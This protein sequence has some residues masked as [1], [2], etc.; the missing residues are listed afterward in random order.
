MRNE[1]RLPLVAV[2]TTYS[3]QNCGSLHLVKAVASKVRAQ[4]Q[5]VDLSTA[6]C[7]HGCWSFK[8][9]LCPVQKIKTKFWCVPILV[10]EV[11]VS[12]D[13][14]SLFTFRVTH[15]VWNAIHPDKAVFPLQ[16]ECCFTYRLLILRSYQWRTGC[17]T[18]LYWP[19]TQMADSNG[20]S[21]RKKYAL[22]V[23]QN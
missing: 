13:L 9:N 14:H 18:V 12:Y 23:L 20:Y 21:E 11:P 8:P 6:F 3:F 5:T 16:V 2:F 4:I 17:S 15:A 10:C 1:F 22:K 19:R 7:S